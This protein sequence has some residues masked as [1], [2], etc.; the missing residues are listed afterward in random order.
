MYDGQSLAVG[1]EKEIPADDEQASESSTAD[2]RKRIKVLQ[3]Q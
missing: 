2:S 3:R 1:K